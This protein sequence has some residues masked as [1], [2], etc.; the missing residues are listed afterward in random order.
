MKVSDSEIARYPTLDDKIPEAVP[1]ITDDEINEALRGGS[2]IEGVR[3]RIYEYFTENRTQQEKVRFL[4]DEYGIGGHSHALSGSGGSFENYSG[5]GIE[6]TKDGCAKVQL[7]WN[8]AEKRIT[9]LIRTDRY[10]TSEARQQYES[11][12]RIKQFDGLYGEYIAVKEAHPD[13]RVLFQVGDFFEMFGE[14]AEHAAEL[15]DIHVTNRTVADGERVKM[16]GIPSFRL[17]ENI[18]KLR[19]RYDVTIL[20]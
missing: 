1:F 3:G 2:H 7:S 9:E 4:K 17:E 12:K 20:R 6:F 5:K 14:D 18:E 15:L 13:D 16:C 8:N 10:F 19:G 11:A